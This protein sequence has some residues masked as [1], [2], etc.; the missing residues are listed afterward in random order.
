VPAGY[1]FNANGEE[2]GGKHFGGGN[3]AINVGK[4]I[5]LACPEEDLISVDME[6]AV[7]DGLSCQ[8]D[9]HCRFLREIPEI[10]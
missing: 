10:R 9:I 6:I 4:D 5:G 7:K 8:K 3:A 1:L 2:G